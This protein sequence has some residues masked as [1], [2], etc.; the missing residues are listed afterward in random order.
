MSMSGITRCGTEFALVSAYTCAVW[1]CVVCVTAMPAVCADA[2][3]VDRH[4]HH[5]PRAAGVHA[6]IYGRVRDVAVGRTD[7]GVAEAAVRA[8]EVAEYLERA[9]DEIAV[10]LERPQRRGIQPFAAEDA[11]HVRLG[12][13]A[14]DVVGAAVV[15]FRDREFRARVVGGN[16]AFSRGSRLMPSPEQQSVIQLRLAIRRNPTGCAAPPC[17]RR[18]RPARCCCR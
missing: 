7:A 17:A 2:A 8:I 14:G 11:E 13:G 4:D 5:A 12:D 1:N 9:V 6:G 15:V 16:L 3:L 18:R 10:R